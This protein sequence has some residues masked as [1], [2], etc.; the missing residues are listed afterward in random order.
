MS[1]ARSWA[2][3]AALLMAAAIGHPALGAG[4]AKQARAQFQRAE[5]AYNMGKFTEA[6]A[7]YQAAYEAKPLPGLLFNIAQCHRNLGNQERAL[8]FYRRYLALDPQTSNRA[9]VE[10]LIA[11]TEQRRAQES[12]AA[13]VAPPRVTSAPGGAALAPPP[14]AAAPP[15]PPSA[16]PPPVAAP[17]GDHASHMP[18]LAAPPPRDEEVPPAFVKAGPP[19]PATG[20]PLHRRWGFWAAIGGVAAAGAT[21][22]VLLSKGHGSSTPP[23]GGLG[24]I[25][26][27]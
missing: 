18:D 7:A 5:A 24:A 14:Q 15:P 2:L 23:T 12:A 3:L 27:R 16:S 6:L 17:A 19:A 22:A 25:D 21:T 9:T 10:Q 8:F 4:D 1:T 13:G 20:K 11:E 26:W